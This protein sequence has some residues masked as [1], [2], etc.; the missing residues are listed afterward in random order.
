VLIRVM[1]GGARDGEAISLADDALVDVARTDLARTMNLR[2]APAMIRVIRHP[3]GIPQYNVGHLAL[4]EQIDR[5]LEQHPGLAVAGNSYRGVAINS[6]IAEAA[7]VAE[8]ALT[9]A[10]SA[11]S[12]ATV[13]EVTGALSL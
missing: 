9:A 1:V 7:A 10:A 4:L 8:S 5:Q 13:H 6:C 11:P 3:R 12:R 2:A